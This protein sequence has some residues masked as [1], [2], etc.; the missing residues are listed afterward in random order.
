VVRRRELKMYGKALTDLIVRNESIDELHQEFLNWKIDVE[1]DY[2]S[3][4]EKT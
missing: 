3:S 1:S 4:H 2:D